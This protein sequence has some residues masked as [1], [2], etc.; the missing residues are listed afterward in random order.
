MI[1]YSFYK[2]FTLTL[3]TTVVL[4]KRQRSFLG[5]NLFYKL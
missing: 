2:D 4:Y 5:E 1:V 3:E